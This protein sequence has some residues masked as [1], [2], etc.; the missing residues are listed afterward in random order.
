M[1]KWWWTN[2]DRGIFKETQMMLI[3]KSDGNHQ[4][5]IPILKSTD[6]LWFTM[7]K[8]RLPNSWA[9]P[10]NYPSHETIFSIETH[11]DLGIPLCKETCKS[12]ESSKIGLNMFEP[13]NHGSVPIHGWRFIHGFSSNLMDILTEELFIEHC[14]FPFSRFELP[15]GFAQRWFI[16]VNSWHMIGKHG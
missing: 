16:S 11:G 2:G 15:R 3:T 14:D 4:N 6:W 8:R 7:Q 1:E 10:P 13:M 9:C 12:G 5:S